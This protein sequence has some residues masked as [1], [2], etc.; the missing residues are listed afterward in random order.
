MLWT[1]EN[2]RRARELWV[3]GHSAKKIGEIMGCSRNAIAG[4]ISRIGL[5]RTK[6]S[7]NS[8]PPYSRRDS[9]GRYTTAG[10]VMQSALVRKPLPGKRRS[11][12]TPATVKDAPMPQASDAA[13]SSYRKEGTLTLMELR[14]DTCRW[15][16]GDPQSFDFGYCGATTDG[17]CPYCLIH[18]RVAYGLPRGHGGFVIKASAR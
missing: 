5:F 4:L 3:A 7:R 13:S 16:I 6:R 9:S 10:Q 1:D 8:T 12:G 11:D 17:V 18:K 15:P 2:K 14:R